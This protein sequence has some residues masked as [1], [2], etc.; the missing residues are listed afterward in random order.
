MRSSGSPA[1]RNRSMSRASQGTMMPV[2]PAASRVAIVFTQLALSAG[3]DASTHS[4]ESASCD[5]SPRTSSSPPGRMT[6]STAR[7][8]RL[9]SAG[10]RQRTSIDERTERGLFS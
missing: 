1:L 4:S 8:D 9:A 6:P 3:T 2:A 5:R 10:V 7:A